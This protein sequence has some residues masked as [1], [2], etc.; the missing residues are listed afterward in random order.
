[1]SILHIGYRISP[2]HRGSVSQQHLFT[3]GRINSVIHSR[4][5]IHN[6]SLF[7]LHLALDKL[8]SMR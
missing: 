5:S 4:P 3:L 6:F 1:M 7:I 2:I 8:R